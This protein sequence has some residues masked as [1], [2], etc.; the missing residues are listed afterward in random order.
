MA[1]GSMKTF[2]HY[3]EKIFPYTVS[4]VLEKPVRH[5]QSG[6]SR[7]LL[8]FLPPLWRTGDLPFRWTSL[9]DNI[10][11]QHPLK[12]D[13]RGNALLLPERVLLRMPGINKETFW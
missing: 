10:G 7:M 13:I 8:L 1:Q 12:Q 5:S 3:R 4:Q 11:E 6:A 9:K 2:A